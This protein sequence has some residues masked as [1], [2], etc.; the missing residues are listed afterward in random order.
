M[1]D[2][3]LFI[4]HANED[5]AVVNLIVQY[6]EAHG[7]PCW[8]AARDIPPQAI[9]AEAITSAIQSASACA[10]IVSNA[11]NASAAIKRELELAS[12]HGRPFIPIRI[13]GA[14]PG[15]GF[16]YYLRNTQWIDYQREQDRGLDRIVAHLKGADVSGGANRAPPP[17]QPRASRGNL[18]PAVLIAAALIISG[19]AAWYLLRPTSTPETAATANAAPA[20]TATPVQAVDVNGAWNLNMTCANGAS[21]VEPDAVFQDA[22]YQRQ[23][24]SASAAG[25]TRLR[26]TSSD[27]QSIHLIGEIAF[28]G[29]NVMPVDAQATT[30]DNG[31]TFTGFGLYGVNQ[32]CPFI[33]TRQR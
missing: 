9:Y 24:V 8:I 23:F 22:R 7:V 32:N 4:S 28:A 33:A 20:S 18:M 17:P 19:G 11:S 25:E 26:M 30:S 13:D 10:V 15:P 12:H 14:E 29:G 5:S 31:A 2:Q 3:R 27:V 1:A 6:L 21:L 16:D